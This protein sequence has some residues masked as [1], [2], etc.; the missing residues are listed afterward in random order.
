MQSNSNRGPSHNILPNALHKIKK[1]LSVQFY[2]VLF[3][4]KATLLAF[5]TMLYDKKIT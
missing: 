1:Y 4:I 3:L 2:T 5:N